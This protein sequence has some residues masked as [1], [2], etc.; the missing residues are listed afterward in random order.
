MMAQD[1]SLP[2][3]NL[4]S[5]RSFWR[6]LYWVQEKL[7]LSSGGPL[8]MVCCGIKYACTNINVPQSPPKTWSRVILFLTW[9][10]MF[11]FVGS[12]SVT[13][14]SIASFIGAAIPLSMKWYVGARTRFVVL[15]RYSSRSGY[16]LPYRSTNASG[17]L[18]RSEHPM[19]Q[20]QKWYGSTSYSSLGNCKWYYRYQA[21]RASLFVS[22]FERIRMF[23]RGGGGE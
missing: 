5:R 13:R 12:T 7:I 19:I 1:N 11:W 22:V 10:H 18:Y 17:L 15:Y 23:P 2:S 20:Y 3:K 6:F 9:S 16:R 14:S 8:R 4:R 21:G